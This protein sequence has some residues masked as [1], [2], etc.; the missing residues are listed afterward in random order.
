MNKIDFKQ[1]KFG[2]LISGKGFYV[3]LC[4]SIL[5]VGAAGLFA[6]TSTT[7]KLKDQ[8]SAENNSTSQTAEWGYED[9]T[10]K[11]NKAETE[12]PKE[13]TETTPATSAV[14]KKT[15]VEDDYNPSQYTAAQPL[16]M[17]LNGEIVNEFSNG[18]LIKSKTLKS[19]KTHDGVDIKGTLGDQIKSMTG[20][21]VIEVKEDPLWG[22]CVII[23][24]G[25]GLEGHYYNLNKTVNVQP[26]QKV[27]PGTVIGA[28]GD[29]AMNEIAEGSHLHFGLK[30][31]GSWVDPILTIQAE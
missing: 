30:K 10:E 9:F 27:S 21:K 28:I 29:T 4:A 15:V 7:D 23:D 16:V 20:G 3:V 8:L 5:T 22:V 1:S 19:W 31:N 18:N 24:H 14:P 26:D 13:T 11:V 2:K 25:N 12:I 17:P 6:Y